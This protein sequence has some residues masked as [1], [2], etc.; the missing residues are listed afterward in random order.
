MPREISDIKN[1]SCALNFSAVRGGGTL[2]RGT[3]RENAQLEDG[4]RRRRGRAIGETGIGPG[5]KDIIQEEGAINST[6]TLKGGP[7]KST[8]VTNARLS[9][10][11]VWEITPLRPYSP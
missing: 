3:E 7:Y 4:N 1:V 6:A 10:G 9:I 11:R 5:K 2:E 8:S